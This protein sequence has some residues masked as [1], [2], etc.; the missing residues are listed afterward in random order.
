MIHTTINAGVCG[1]HTTV[2][3]RSDDMQLVSLQI[4]SECEKIRGLAEALMAPIDAYQASRPTDQQVAEA[5]TW[6][7]ELKRREEVL[8]TGRTTRHARPLRPLDIHFAAAAV[9]LGDARAVERPHMRQE[10]RDLFGALRQEQR[11]HWRRA[12]PPSN[13]PTSR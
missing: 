3:A 1:F 4:A 11:Q 9:F 2:D 13:R 6:I 8:Q 12:G 10:V 7:A 5:K